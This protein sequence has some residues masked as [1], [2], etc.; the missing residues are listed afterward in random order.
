MHC[1]ASS[2]SNQS[3]HIIVYIASTHAP[4]C[5]CQTD[6]GLN[7]TLYGGMFVS[8]IKYCTLVAANPVTTV[9][10]H[11]FVQKVRR[12]KQTIARCEQSIFYDI[13]WGLVF[14]TAPRARNSYT[15]TQVLC[16]SLHWNIWLALFPCVFREVRVAEPLHSYK[17]R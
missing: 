11:R 4:H 12:P 14:V 16:M 6:W 13:F 1:T 2:L 9:K 8:S 7:A 15:R 10:C 5:S 3:L 17:E